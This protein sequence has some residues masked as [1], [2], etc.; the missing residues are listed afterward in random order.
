MGHGDRFLVPSSVMSE[1]SDYLK[2]DG[3]RNLSPCPTDKEP[4]PA[5]HP[6]V[7]FSDRREGDFFI[8]F[9]QILDLSLS[10][11]EIDPGLHDLLQVKCSGFV[12]I[13]VSGQ[14]VRCQNEFHLSILISHQVTTGSA[15][16]AFKGILQTVP[17]RFPAEPDLPSNDVLPPESE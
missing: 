2:E 6:C 7:L 8:M 11:E 9:L 1:S 15:Y 17:V 14:A 12:D 3:T 10:L 5:S 16:R 4:V 13:P